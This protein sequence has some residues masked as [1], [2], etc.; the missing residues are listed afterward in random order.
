[1]EAS[2]YTQEIIRFLENKKYAIG[3]LLDM[4]KA[5]D[6]V[7]QS[8]LS[9][10]LSG[11]GIRGL[12]HK[13]FMSYLKDRQQYV[14][15]EYFDSHTREIVNVRSDPK[16]INSSISQ[17]SVVGCLLFLTYIND[18]LKIMDEPCTLFAED[19]SLLTSVDD[20]VNIRAKLDSIMTR[21]NNWLNNHHLKINLNK[22]KLITFHPYQ[23]KPLKFQYSFN[24]KIIECVNEINLLGLNIDKHL[25]WKCHIL[26]AY[27]ELEKPLHRP[28]NREFS[29]AKVI[30]SVVPS[31]HDT[32]SDRY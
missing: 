24:G 29:T 28:I 9:K 1:L 23:K 17:G 7:Q 14:E 13:W 32:H 12:A 31:G 27:Y 18:I 21:T 11:V 8:I 19:V 5:C 30:R 4:T 20:D 16:N 22:T 3:I 25:N 6:R 15:I 2:K 26:E 10:K